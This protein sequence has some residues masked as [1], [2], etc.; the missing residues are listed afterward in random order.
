MLVIRLYFILSAILFICFSSSE[1]NPGRE[2][3]KSAIF[4]LGDSVSEKIYNQGL[5]DILKCNRTD[6][7]IKVLVEANN[8]TG[9]MCF[10][11]AYRG[12]YRIGYM[13]HWGVGIIL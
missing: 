7:N 12:L 6:P 4:F 13:R 2:K 3:A 1:I 5:I 8:R 9:L 10:P 11:N